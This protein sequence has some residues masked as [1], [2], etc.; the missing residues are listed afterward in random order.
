MIDPE[1]FLKQLGFEEG[2]VVRPTKEY[3]RTMSR[4]FVVGKILFIDKKRGLLYIDSPTGGR[5]WISASWCVPIEDPLH[6]EG[7]VK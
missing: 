7:N 6:L 2:G 4:S 1:R 5:T 3:E